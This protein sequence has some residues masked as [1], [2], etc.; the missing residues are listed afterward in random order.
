MKILVIGKNSQLGLS[1]KKVLNNLLMV[2]D[3]FFVGR[4][5]IDLTNLD[6]I[7]RYFSEHEVDVIINCSAYTKVDQAEK[8][9][10]IANKVNHLALTRLAEIANR[11][12][13]KLIHISTDYVFDGKKQKPYDEDDETRPINNYG[14]TKR[15]GEMALL[16]ALPNNGIIL[17]T[18]WLYSEFGDNFVKKMLKLGIMESQINVVSDQY[19]SPTYCADLAKVIINIIKKDIFQKFN[20]KTQIYHYSNTGFVSWHG[21]TKKIFELAEINCIINPIKSIDYDR[22][23]D[24]PKNSSLSKD[25]ITKTLNIKIPEWD[26]S[27]RYCIHALTKC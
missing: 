18:S 23:A 6:N 21:F 16:T 24:I 11:K 12:N 25:K 10:H 8:D 9:E 19:S 7:S 4:A 15:A 27:L 22:A 14:K 5:E 2:D 17:R 26:E 1:I 13:I 3:Y 20:N